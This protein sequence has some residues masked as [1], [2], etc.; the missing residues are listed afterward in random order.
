MNTTRNPHQE[1]AARL[2]RSVEK[3]DFPDNMRWDVTL[4]HL[5]G[6]FPED[7]WPL[8]AILVRAASG[9]RFKF[10]ELVIDSNAKELS[11]ESFDKLVARKV[12]QTVAFLDAQ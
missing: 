8:P 11:E 3:L 4:P 1:F 6:S 5:W 12:E 9:D 7:E 2:R 10:A